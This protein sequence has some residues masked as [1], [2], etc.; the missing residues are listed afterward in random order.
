[1]RR[2]TRVVGCA[3]QAVWTERVP[4]Q[5]GLPTPTAD[6]LVASVHLAAVVRELGAVV[7]RGE[8]ICESGP[9]G[10]IL[11]TCTVR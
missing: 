5:M 8:D 9:R 3:V 2:H 1:M 10:Y 11:R 7:E 4:V 6:M